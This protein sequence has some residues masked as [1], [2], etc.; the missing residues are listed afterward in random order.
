VAVL[1]GIGVV[2]GNAAKANAKKRGNAHRLPY[3]GFIVGKVGTTEIASRIWQQTSSDSN[4]AWGVADEVVPG[5][6][7]LVTIGESSVAVLICGELF[8]QRARDSIVALSP[9][10][11]VDLGHVS[12]NTGVTPSMEGM[13][14]R[15]GSAVAHSQHVAEHGSA[16]M[17]FVDATRQRESVPVVECEWVGNDDFWVAWRVRQF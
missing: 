13:A 7:R 17:H 14:V 9:G 12:M 2:A 16:S 1:A 3:F 4:N 15:S 5:R 10:L 6:D 11:I 8:S